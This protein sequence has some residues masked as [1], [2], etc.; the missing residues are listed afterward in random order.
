MTRSLAVM[1]LASSAA[2]AQAQPLSSSAFQEADDRMM[3]GMH[4]P[5]TGLTDRDFVD[6]ML[7][8]HQ[9]ALEMAQVELRYGTDP[10][11]KKLAHDIIVNQQQEIVFMR[12]WQQA[13]EPRRL[14]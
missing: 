10:A 1:L 5:Y 11:L 6:H 8:H 2:L 14:P 4:A 3:M 12:R 13:H 7:P 9:G